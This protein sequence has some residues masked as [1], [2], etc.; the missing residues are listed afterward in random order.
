MTHDTNYTGGKLIDCTGQPFPA[1]WTVGYWGGTAAPVF[2]TYGGQMMIPAN[3]L[4]LE[5][6]SNGEPSGCWVDAATGAIM[7]DGP[8]PDGTYPTGAELRD[9]DTDE[10]I[11]SA[12]PAQ[13]WASQATV[14]G[15]IV[16]DADG[17]V[18]T[19]GTWD[20]QQ[21]GVRKCYVL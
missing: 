20:A 19:D 5:W 1:G 15:Y 21:P 18:V 6:G 12:T 14:E 10:A 9:S 16:V 3:N 11:W 8:V 7:V 4:E 13:W 17:S 2:V